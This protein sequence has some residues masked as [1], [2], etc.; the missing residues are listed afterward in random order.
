MRSRRSRVGSKNWKQA[1]HKDVDWYL[2][3]KGTYG[4]N[5]EWIRNGKRIKQ[6]KGE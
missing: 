6:T 2:V 5:T 1:G 3:H 4:A